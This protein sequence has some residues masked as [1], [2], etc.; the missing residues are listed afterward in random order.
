MSKASRVPSDTWQR[1]V[2]VGIAEDGSKIYETVY[3]SSKEEVDAKCNE[4]TKKNQ[5]LRQNEWQKENMDRVSVILPK[6]TKERITA[7]GE[8]V[9]KFIREAT[10][11]E[12]ERR[13]G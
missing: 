1:K 13:E 10:L 3:G 11:A 9:N 12:L 7:L 4:I 8:T 5:Y 2:A 6:G